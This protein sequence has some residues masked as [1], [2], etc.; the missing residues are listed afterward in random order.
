MIEAELVDQVAFTPRPEFAFH[1]PLI[2][3][4]A[5]RSQLA[6]ARAD[7]HRRLAAVLVGE[8]DPDIPG[9]QAALIAEHYESAGDLDEAF[10]WHMRA[11]DQL[12]F[13]DIDASRLSWQRAGRVADT[14]PADLP[15]REAMRI[16][17]RALLIA[18]NFRAIGPVD[19]AGFEELRMLTD[20]A[21]DKLSLAMALS[22]RVT[23]LAFR[24]RYPEA[25]QEANELV[26][27]IQSIVDPIWELALLIGASMAKLICGEIAEGIRLADRMIEIADGDFLKGGFDD[28]VAPC[29]RHDAS[30]GRTNVFGGDGLEARNGRG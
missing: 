2:R 16:A 25:L 10:A 27:L 4:V 6:S 21:G 13:R 24:G 29:R 22:G 5:Y 30:C 23:T 3:A 14:M 7:L 8:G 28:R 18:S 26:V 15:G 12:R 9:E 1:H 19:D 11:G 20:R 17:P